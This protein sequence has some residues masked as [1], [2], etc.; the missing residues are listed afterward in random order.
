MPPALVEGTESYILFGLMILL[1]ED[2]FYQAVLY[3]VFALGVTITIL[4]RL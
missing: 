3:W 2:G 4:Q 1:G